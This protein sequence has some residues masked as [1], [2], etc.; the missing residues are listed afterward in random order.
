MLTK[1][2]GVLRGVGDRAG[3]RGEKGRDVNVRGIKGM[4]GLDRRVC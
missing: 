4:G 2:D 1:V 3:E